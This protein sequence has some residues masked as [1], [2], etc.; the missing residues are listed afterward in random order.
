MEV[1]WSEIVC[2]MKVSAVLL[3]M[4]VM[5]FLLCMADLAPLDNQDNKDETIY[6]ATQGHVLSTGCS[7][8]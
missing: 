5:C 6:Q 3:Q 8:N 2:L 4:C 1:D 7:S